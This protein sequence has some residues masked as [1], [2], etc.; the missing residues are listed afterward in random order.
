MTKGIY[1]I[2]SLMIVCILFMSSVLAEPAFIYKIGEDVKISLP[3]FNNNHSKAVEAVDCFITIKNPT[4]KVVA[5]DQN[6]TFNPSGNYNY[7]LNW[8]AAS[9]SGEYPVSIRC[10]DG[11]EYG[12]AAFTFLMTPTGQ[13]QNS[14][15]ENPLL[16]I[17][18]ILAVLLLILA[19]WFRIPPMGF[20]S[21]LIFT[22]LGVYVLIYGFNNV[23][24]LY[25]NASAGVFL[26][27]G[28]VFLFS[29]IVEWMAE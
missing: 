4:Q 26:A 2:V 13:K 14:I 19:V 17:F 6:M 21:G 28:L 7:T 12:S 18:L 1:L 20:L 23:T 22:L 15:L 9:V 16:I 24:S 29:S 25:T 5:D 11:A 27:I 8:E 3:V 10:D